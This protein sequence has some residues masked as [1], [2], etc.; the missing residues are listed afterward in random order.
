MKLFHDATGKTLG[1]AGDDGGVSATEQRQRTIT[2]LSVVV[3]AIAVVAFV[4]FYPGG[5]GTRIREAI[6]AEGR[7]NPAVQEQGVPGGHYEFLATQ[8]GSDQPVGWNPCRE[9]HY[10]V[11]PDGAPPNWETLIKDGIAEVEARTGLAFRS[12]GTTDDR[13]FEDRFAG[14][15]DP[16]PALIGWADDQE[17]PQ[18]E[19]D[20]AGIGGATYAEVGG[21]RTYVTGMVVLDVETDDKLASAKDAEVVQLAVLL[22][23]L[24]H[25]VGLAHVDDR[26]EIMYADGVTRTSYGTGDLDGLARL[27][28]VPCR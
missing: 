4:A 1:G 8:R 14:G 22:H 6:G 17:V 5:L 28:S 2:V 18:L 15:G 3:T 16:L 9:I 21:H 11:N 7:I 20:V 23:E 24:G 13:G 25:L 10:V 26:G 19:G 12:D 27:G